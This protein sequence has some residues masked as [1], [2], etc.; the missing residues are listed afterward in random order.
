MA[1]VRR[2]APDGGGGRP[3][4]T[5]IYKA[6]PP[7][8]PHLPLILGG[9]AVGLVLIVV[10]I[11]AATGG[12]KEPAPAK[13]KKPAVEPPKVVSAE[14][15]ELEMQ[16][17]MMCE[18][19]TRLVT[20]RLKNDPAAHRESV[21]KDLERGIKYLKEGLAA[22]ERA[23]M[24]TG[25]DYPIGDP[26]RTRDQAI[27]V[28]SA[29]LEKEGLASCN[30]G[31]RIIQSCE[32]RMTGRE[33]SDD[34][35]KKLREDLLKG[36]GLITDGMNLFDRSNQVSG[37]MFDTSKYGQARKLANNKLGELK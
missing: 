27:Q 2:M 3:P 30:E 12:R 31:Y 34:E 11:A 35:K 10:I 4:S 1:T 23:R 5:R 28:L 25:R 19:G 37:N 9:A 14:V 21:R 16:G 8:N 22:Y 17:R 13:P 18:E 15:K 6:D 26:M 29:D 20:P 33:L 32:S 36:V 7:G 24:R